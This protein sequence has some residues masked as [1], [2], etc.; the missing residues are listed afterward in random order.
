MPYVA[1]AVYLSYFPCSRL[2]AVSAYCALGVV[3]SGV[4]RYR[5]LTYP[6]PPSRAEYLDMRSGVRQC[7]P[8]ASPRRRTCWTRR[9]VPS[10]D[11]HRACDRR[12]RRGAVTG[13]GGDLLRAQWSS[14]SMCVA[15]GHRQAEASK[16]SFLPEEPRLPLVFWAW[17]PCGRLPRLVVLVEPAVDEGTDQGASRDTASEALPTQACVD[18]LF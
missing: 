9:E 1:K 12:G 14:S 8:R 6:E 4:K 2:P 10:R 11:S 15:P 7:W 16:I 17:R 18:A 5:L 13:S 3:R